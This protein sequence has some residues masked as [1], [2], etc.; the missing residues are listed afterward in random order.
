MLQSVHPES[1]YWIV[2]VPFLQVGVAWASA[3]AFPHAPQFD[4]SF[5]VSTQ[6][7]AQGV[8]PGGHDTPPPAPPLPA[9]PPAPPTPGLPPAPPTLALVLEAEVD[10]ACAPP[11]AL[12]AEV[13]AAC[14]P[15]VPCPPPP[16]PVAAAP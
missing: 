7:P 1:Q 6:T 4:T 9:W 8:S 16:V 2:H 10:A 13:D 5:A 12:E 3:H 11:V 15:P 14:A